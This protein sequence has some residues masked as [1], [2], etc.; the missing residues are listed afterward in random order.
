MLRFLIPILLCGLVAYYSLPV[1]QAPTPCPTP[2]VVDMS[3]AA[4]TPGM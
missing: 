2:P 4:Q 1:T 3:G